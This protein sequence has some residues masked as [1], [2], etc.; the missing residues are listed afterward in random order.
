M[1]QSVGS[2]SKTRVNTSKKRH[3][4]VAQVLGCRVRNPVMRKQLLS[5][6]SIMVLAAACTSDPTPQR[7]GNSNM[8]AD[9]GQMSALDAGQPVD[10]GPSTEQTTCGPVTPGV[11]TCCPVDGKGCGDQTCFYTTGAINEP[12]CRDLAMATVGA[13]QEC[14]ANLNN[15]E[16][17]YTCVQVGDMGGAR[18]LKV[19]RAG[20]NPDCAT[21][22]DPMGNPYS[23]LFTFQGNPSWG[24]CLPTP[25]ECVPYNDTCPTGEYCSVISMTGQKG[26][27]PE[28][29]KNIG[30][31]CNPGECKKG[32]ICV[33]GACEIPCDPTNAM[34]C[35]DP[36][37]TCSGELGFSDGTRLGFGICGSSSCNPATSA[38]DCMMG[39]NCELTA[40]NFEC[41]PEGTAT[42]GQPCSR[43]MTYCAQGNIC[44]NNLTG[45]TGDQCY[46]VCD[47]MAGMN[48]CSA[49]VC[50]GLMDQDGNP[51]GGVSGWGVCI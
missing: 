18:C 26:C 2:S 31:A 20:T 45:G 10:A 32:G 42:A 23:C 51:V 8:N 5:I 44:I 13:E 9:A 33:N 16:G 25:T 6:F 28:G 19:C 41:V 12:Q 7:K 46:E 21:E 11:D 48:T 35:T 50:Q 34:S 49:G 39:E 43:G 14:D 29:T 38:T 17:G 24:L 3:F 36:N 30:D 37:Q 27:I 4:S 40:T 15:C 47:T 22:Q 1:P